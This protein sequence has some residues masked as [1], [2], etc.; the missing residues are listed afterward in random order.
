MAHSSVR[1]GFEV[2][3]SG[4][5][6]GYLY[7]RTTYDVH[8]IQYAILPNLCGHIEQ[9]LEH[10][11]R[12]FYPCMTYNF[13]EKSGDNHYNCRLAY[14]PELT[15]QIYQPKRCRF[16]YPYFYLSIKNTLLRK[17]SGFFKENSACRKDHKIAKRAYKEYY[18]Y[19]NDIRTYGKKALQFAEENGHT[20]IVSPEDL[21]I[22]IRQTMGSIS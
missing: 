9:L 16:P 13:D 11:V 17:A 4:Y 6:T 15:R 12:R 8:P 10:G 5:S 21:I 3:L 18:R 7:Q 2:V 14:Y 22:L 1:I 19:M 20:V